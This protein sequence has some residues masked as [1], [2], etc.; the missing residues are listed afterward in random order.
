[1]VAEPE[2]G[3]ARAWLIRSII[4]RQSTLQAVLR[5][6][7]AEE[8]P[9]EP[10]PAFGVG[11]VRHESIGAIVV[12]SSPGIC[13]LT[14][15]VSS[16]DEALPADKLL[17]ALL[18]ELT[19]QLRAMA[20]QQ[21][22]VDDEQRSMIHREIMEMQERIEMLSARTG[23]RRG[24]DNSKLAAEVA[25][26]S[27]AAS[28]EQQTLEARANA[29]AGRINQ[30]RIEAQKMPSDDTVQALTEAVELLSKQLEADKAFGGDR[31]R[32]ELNLA[33]A[34]AELARYRASLAE[35]AHGQRLNELRRRL[36][37]TSIELE[38]AKHK[39]AILE[40]A[41]VEVQKSM[42]ASTEIELL[43]RQLTDLWDAR[44]RIEAKIRSHRPPQVQFIRY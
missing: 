12:S 28:V 37:D 9:S 20:E 3:L 43:Q 8:T 41:L 39:R 16:F 31:L 42:V 6:M 30:L 26:Q 25:L 11:P 22:G 40:Q 17:D 10:R 21:I 36:D 1:M 33:N 35:G 7:K 13:E 15:D 34:R 19:K 29:I 18:K 2:S 27:L 44:S 38:E 14:L 4:E 23:V 5:E 32:T 24:S